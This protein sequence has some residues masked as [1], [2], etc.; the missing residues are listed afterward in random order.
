MTDLVTRTGKG[1]ALTYG[2]M[3]GNWTELETRTG[4]GW[5][6]LVAD[7]QV[8]GGLYQPEFKNFRDGIWAYAFSPTTMNE[9]YAAFHVRHDYIAGTMV[10]PHV[11]WSVNTTSTGTVRWGVEYTLA[12]RSD[13]GADGSGTNTGTIAFG[14]TQTLY[15]DHNIAANEQYEH[16]VNE[17][18][19]G[20]GIP[21]TQLQEDA[22]ILCR[23]FR[24]AEH[25][26]DTFPDDIFLLTVDIH[27]QCNSLATPLRYAPFN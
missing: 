23:F 12:R 18:A 8:R 4:S 6:D 17:A 13:Y 20:A 25:V 15:L 22:L 27:Y 5:N 19:D 16:H 7:V 14:A 2:E 21:G 3:D 11:H 10:Y 24:D 26:N 1:S 9:C